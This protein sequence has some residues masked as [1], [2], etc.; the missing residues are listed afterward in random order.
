MGLTTF[1]IQRTAKERPEELGVVG[2]RV[3]RVSPTSRRSWSDK[4]P[5]GTS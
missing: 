2:R 5:S 1:W 4:L 3:V